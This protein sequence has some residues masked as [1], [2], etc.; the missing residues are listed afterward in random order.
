M[1]WRRFVTYLWN[2]PRKRRYPCRLLLM[3]ANLCLFGSRAIKM[4]L[5]LLLLLLLFV[6]LFNLGIAFSLRYQKTTSEPALALMVL[7]F[8]RT[9]SDEF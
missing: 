2:D 6:S 9:C 3:I 4:L 7:F 8:I 1:E 5:L